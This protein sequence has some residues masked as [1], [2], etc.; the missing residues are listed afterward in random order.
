LTTYGPPSAE[1]TDELARHAARLD[2]L[3][4]YVAT[5]EDIAG[6]LERYLSIKARAKLA[7]ARARLHRD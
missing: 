3:E 1:I 2:A 5:L 7:L 4:G 6:D